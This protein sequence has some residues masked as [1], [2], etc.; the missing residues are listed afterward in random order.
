[1]NYAFLRP[2]LF[3]LDAEKAHALTLASL[4]SLHRLGFGALAGAQQ[5]RCPR[6]V[7]G[8]EFPNP[9]GL[10]AGLDK[11]GD[12]IDALAALGFGFLEIGTVTPRAQRGN[13]QPRLF[14]L[15]H[16][17]A[18]I[19]R[20]GF[21]NAGADHL[22]ERVSQMRYRGALGINIGKNFDTPLERAI[23][24][25]L[26]CLRAVYPFAAYVTVNISSPNTASLRD[27]Q[28]P[29]ELAPLLEALKREQSV[30]ADKHGKYVPL[31]VKIAPDLDTGA[32]AAIAQVLIIHR[33]DAAIA[34]NTTLAR[35]RVRGQPHGDEGGGLS[36][37]PLTAKTREVVQELVRVLDAALPVIGVGGIMA[38]DDALALMDAGAE[39]VQLYTGL[40]YRGP[41]L[42]SEVAAALCGRSDAP[43][44]SRSAT[45]KAVRRWPRVS[46]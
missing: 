34:T 9:V 24:D 45:R 18:L 29:G 27:L 19:N 12:Y 42:I 36:G 43:R 6:K 2:F 46:P 7:M 11:N 25:Y 44:V 13:P 10:A 41:A 15:P 37:A 32:I 3:A 21:N 4:D 31:A 20:M 30:L 16:A 26:F 1:M 38:A 5:L 39:L 8:I 33:I 23:D 17:Q 14:R 22:L 35:D 28:K 40:I